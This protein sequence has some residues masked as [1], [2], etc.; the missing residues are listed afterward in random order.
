[1][2]KIGKKILMDKIQRLNPKFM[3][4]FV[5][6]IEIMHHALLMKSRK[7]KVEGRFVSIPGI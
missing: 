3:I 4:A 5:S 7:I 1:M 6:A 2:R